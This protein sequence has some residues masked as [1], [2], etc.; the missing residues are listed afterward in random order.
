MRAW[1]ATAFTFPLVLTLA[2][3]SPTTQPKTAPTLTE[4]PPKRCVPL[5]R[6][7]RS[8][9][10]D[11]STILFHMR[12]GAVWRN[13]LPERCYGL[14]M[15]GGF[16]YATGLTQLCDLDIIQVLGGAYSVCGLGRFEPLE[17]PQ[18]LESTEIDVRPGS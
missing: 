14:R 8:E 15:Q 10:V 1:S 11:D 9:I 3:S 5:S 13:R 4:S 2:C 7:Y 6:I 17:P 16:G 12:D 18:G